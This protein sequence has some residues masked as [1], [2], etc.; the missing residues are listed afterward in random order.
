[1]VLLYYLHNPH[2][3][4]SELQQRE[5]DTGRNAVTLTS[6]PILQTMAIVGIYKD[7]YIGLLELE[8]LHLIMI[9]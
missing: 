4:H 9:S 3:R 2:R 6:D 5:S 1:M 7:M 8:S